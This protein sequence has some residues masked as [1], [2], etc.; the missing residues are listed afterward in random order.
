MPAKLSER[1]N[2]RRGFFEKAEL[3]ALLPHLPSPIDDMARFAFAT[4][5]RRGELVDLSWE[6][7]TKDE[8]RLGTT[9]NGE[10]RSLP[11]AGDLKEI[12]DRRRKAR[13]YV[14]LSGVGI[15]AHVFHRNGRPINR[16][17]FGKRWRRACVRAGLGQRVKDEKGVVRYVGRHFHD[18]RRTAARNMIR[19]GVP[20]SIAMRVTGHD[21]EAMFRRYDIA[22]DRDKA[23]ALAAA[24][25]F[26][27]RQP[28]E[29]PNLLSLHQ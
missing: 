1:D 29:Q 8:I 25:Q 16:T 10:P 12:I 24:R 22:D 21:T 14:T 5:W 7:V 20:Q 17:I 13:E 2:V 15:S 3:D 26:V 18:F 4:G 11:L 9:K 23:A 28:G 19:A 27:E 6:A